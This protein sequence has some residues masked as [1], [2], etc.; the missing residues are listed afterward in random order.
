MLENLIWARRFFLK[1]SALLDIRHFPKMQSCTRS[2]KNKR[3]RLEKMAKS[4]IMCPILGPNFL[5][6]EI[7]LLRHCS[8]LLSDAI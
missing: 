3:W 4:L 1:F 2:K 5:F 7:S 6:R 8:K